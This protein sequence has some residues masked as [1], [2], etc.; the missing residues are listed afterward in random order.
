[1]GR[2]LKISGRPSV[3][4]SAVWSVSK[5][6]VCSNHPPTSG[7][8]PCSG[9]KGL[10]GHWL[11]L[12]IRRVS[13][14]CLPGHHI[15]VTWP[16][17]LPWASSHCSETLS[18]PPH[19][20]CCLPSG[21][22]LGS[23]QERQDLTQ[24]PLLQPPLCWVLPGHSR[25]GLALKTC[26]GMCFPRGDAHPPPRAA[27]V[28]WSVWTPA[29]SLGPENPEGLF[30]GTADLSGQSRPVMTSMKDCSFSQPGR[31]SGSLPRAPTLVFLQ[32]A[33]PT[34]MGRPP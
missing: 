24:T 30:I 29:F 27:G 8:V 18:L 32:L 5:C 2:L 13:P 17:T 33:R 25:A 20:A 16:R 10:A 3:L 4:C 12:G 21:P 26:S 15:L 7:S 11:C 28:G 31:C 1:M 22:S 23:L 19:D 14:L 34:M 9:S 6:W